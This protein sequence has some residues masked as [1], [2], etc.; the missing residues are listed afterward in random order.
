M[1]SPSDG[2]ATPLE[3][4]RFVHLRRFCLLVVWAAEDF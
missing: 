4:P 3:H 1:L 2:F